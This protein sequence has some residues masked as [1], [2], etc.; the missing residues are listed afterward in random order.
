MNPLIS[1]SP[2]KP[3]L[4]SEEQKSRVRQFI[5]ALRSGE[6]RQCAGALCIK[7]SSSNTSFCSVCSLGVACEVFRKDTK[8]G[9]WS[10][11]GIFSE[12][13]MQTVELPIEVREYYGFTSTSP[14][15]LLEDG[16]TL[17]SALFLNDS[18]KYT[19]GQIADAFERTYL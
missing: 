4:L 17:L 5:D 6:Y 10:F 13:M 18:K 8:Q 1:L 15:V 7:I 16:I 9:E 14:Q 19:F 3:K 2:E 12:F 11:A